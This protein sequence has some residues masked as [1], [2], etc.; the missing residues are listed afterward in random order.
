M[1]RKRLIPVIVGVTLC[2]SA[3]IL[4][5]P[6]LAFSALPTEAPARVRTVQVSR[7]SIVQTVLL[8]GWVRQ[9]QEY[10]ALAPTS[11]VLAQVYVNQGE[12]VAADAPLFRLDSSAQEQALSSLLAAQTWPEE[13]DLPAAV[14]E[15]RAYAEQQLEAR[16]QAAEGALALCTVRAPEDAVVEKVCVNACGAVAAGTPVLLLAGGAQ[17]AVCSAVARDAAKIKSGMQATI[18]S[19]GETLCGG[20]VTGVGAAEADPLTGQTVCS[21]TVRPDQALDLPLGA[22]VDVEIT[23]RRQ[24]GVTVLPVTALTPE[25]TVWWIS[26]GRAWQIPAAVLLDDAASCWVALPEGLE[27]AASPEGLVEGQRVK[28]VTP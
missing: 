8:T 20:V 14:G 7:G 4:I 23:C 13:T 25:E 19:G 16:I 17:Q 3:A 21:V 26:E 15:V 24:D 22:R 5:G 11:G 10:A 27:V 1:N 6:R 28:E 12:A 18:A 9:E 2:V